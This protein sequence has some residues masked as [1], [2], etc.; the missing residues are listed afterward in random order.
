M[1]RRL[2][3]GDEINYDLDRIVVELGFPDDYLTAVTITRD[4]M[5]VIVPVAVR[6]GW[7][8]FN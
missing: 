1:S 4:S 5:C 2:M 8:L 7:P 6:S 3:E